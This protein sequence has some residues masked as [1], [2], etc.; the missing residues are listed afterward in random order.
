[1][2]RFLA[3]TIAACMLLA[4]CGGT[5]STGSSSAAQQESSSGA[6]SEAEALSGDTFTVGMECN[7][8]PFNW[9]QLEEN[10]T[11]VALGDGVSY[12]DGYEDR[13]SV[14]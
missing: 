11:T 2:K 5:P 6:S 12:G 10:D 9:T 1:M 13:K 3:V 14:V 4:G 7:Y 8:A